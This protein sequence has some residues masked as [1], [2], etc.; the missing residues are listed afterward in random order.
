MV[1]DSKGLREQKHGGR[2]GK[3]SGIGDMYIKMY[4]KDS[5]LDALDEWEVIAKDAGITK[6]SLAYRWIAYHSALKAANGDGI[7]FGA[8]KP[9]QVED[10]LSIIEAGPLDA[11]SAERVDALWKKIEHEAPI[12]NWNSHAGVKKD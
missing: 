7:I 9:S 5:I 10:T 6:A 11:K 1:K 3:D 2:W 4:Q 8:S 12:D